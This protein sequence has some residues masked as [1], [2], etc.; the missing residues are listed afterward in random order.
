MNLALVSKG[1]SC[2]FGS[3]PDE[4]KMR[5]ASIEDAIKSREKDER[6]EDCKTIIRDLYK[7][8]N[9]GQSA[10]ALKELKEHLDVYPLDESSNLDIPDPVVTF[11]EAFGDNEAI[12][13]E[14]RKNGFTKPSPIQSQMW[15]VLLSGKDCIGVSQTG[16]G[17]KRSLS[18]LPA[19]LHIDAQLKQHAPNDQSRPSPF[20][21]VLTPTRELA[22]Q[23]EG[24]V[25]KYSYRGYR[26]VCVY[27]GGGRN[28]QMD[29]C[30][31]GV[32]IVIATPGRLAD[33]S[34]VGVIDLARVTYAVLDE[35][36]RMLDMGFEASIRRIL[37]EIRPDKLVALT[38][39]T[40]PPGVRALANRYTK[41]T[42]MAVVG[43]LDLSSCSNVKQYFE[44]I[45]EKDRFERMCEIVNFL[46]QRY[47]K[48]FKMIIF[49]KS[50]IMA[51]HLSS[52]FCMRGVNSQGLHGGR[53]Q[54]D[55]ENSLK[56]LREGKVNILVAT[57]LA[58]RG[59]DIPDI[60]HVV[61][62]DFPN[63][64]EEYV[65]RVGRTGRAGRSGES[66]SFLWWNNR[67]SFAPLIEILERSGQEVPR[68]LRND[69][70]KYA[71]KVARGEDGP[72]PPRK[73]MNQRE[74]NFQQSY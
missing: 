53:S 12:M 13:K 62:F 56:E 30:K 73:N 8:K 68:Q 42:V 26:S 66:M 64:I 23:I 36:D 67:S 44:F 34:A 45:H 40:W 35:A 70:Q 43:T 50:K 6:F 10:E 21:L 16:S 2:M 9:S 7:P 11:E 48:A 15:P 3:L 71:D 29:V 69:A 33:L 51:D 17:K 25:K 60:T 39:A 54:E 19:F 55:R 49:V 72:R 57:D 74:N 58:S 20:V 63:D 28:Q 4:T 65:H 14:I 37:F 24:E 41:E 38:S 32:E 31:G 1:P 5:Y 52:D 27:G 61:N 46:N 59:I 18:F 47:G 22:Q